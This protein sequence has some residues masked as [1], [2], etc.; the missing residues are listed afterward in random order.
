[1]PIQKKTREVLAARELKK[2]AEVFSAEHTSRNKRDTMWPAAAT[3]QHRR[4]LGDKDDSLIEKS[5]EYLRRLKAKHVEE[6][7]TKLS[8]DILTY[9]AIRAA[10]KKEQLA[11]IMGEDS[12]LAAAALDSMVEMGERR[13]LASNMMMD[14]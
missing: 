4:A 8:G 11:A 2:S 3:V 5:K 12:K 14:M 9:D 7:K 13:L 10:R 6:L 1:L